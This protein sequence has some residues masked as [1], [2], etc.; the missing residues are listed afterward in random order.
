MT[1]LWGWL[2]GLFSASVRRQLIWGVALV[3]AAMMTLFVADLTVKQHE[4]LVDS[5]VDQAQSLAETLSVTAITPMLSSD[6]SGLQELMVAVAKYPGV[7]HVMAVHRSGKILAHSDPARRGQY[8]GDLPKFSATAQGKGQI[9]SQTDG[10]VDVVTPVMA[11]QQRLGWVRVG[12]GPSSAAARLESISRSGLLYTLLAIG[13][14]VLLAW[15]LGWRLTRRLSELAKVA[16]S[17]RAGSL[18]HRANALGADELSHLANAFNF[19]L[20]TLET[21]VHNERQLQVELSA[22]KELAQVTLASIGDAVITT[23]QTAHI[24]FMNAV[25]ERLTGWNGEDAVGH[26]VGE[27]FCLID[28]ATHEPL[29]NPVDRVQSHAATRLEHGQPPE[30][31]AWPGAVAPTEGLMLARSGQELAVESSAAPIFA[32]DG[33]VLGGVLV[34]RDVSEKHKIQ[35]RLQWQAGHDPLTGLPNRVLLADRFARALDR[36][37]RQSTR[38]AVCMLDLDQFKPVND[39]YGH[40][41]GDEL[42]VQTAQ[43]LTQ[44]LRGIDTLCRLGGDEFVILF[45]DVEDSSTLYRALERILLL[46]AE[47]FDVDGHRISVSASVGMTVFPLDDSDS[48]TLM[49][50]ADQA[51]YV[52]K[53]SGRNRYHLFDVSQDLQM[54]STRQTL[55][56]VRQA[57]HQGELRLHYQPKVNLRTHK[58]VG[59]EA[60]LRWQHPQEGLVPP[61]QFLPLVEQ[62]DVIV[63]IGEWVTEQALIQMACWRELGDAWPVS[64]NIAARH[65]QRHDFLERLKHILARHPSV[66]PSMLEFEILESVALGD[67]HAMNALMTNCQQLGISFSLDDFG[68]GY[69]SLSYLKHLP[70]QTL[71]IDQSFVR[72]MREDKDDLALVGAVV[73]IAHQFGRQVVAEGVETVEQGQQLLSLGCEIVQGYGIAR[74]M[75]PEAVLGWVQHYEMTKQPEGV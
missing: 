72:N 40:E 24:T 68:T 66:A 38:L 34:F 8:V 18:T 42:L 5:Q 35:Q 49:R 22:E 45:E 13:V 44:E 71:K 62:S 7:V 15:I 31:G 50:H 12:V 16:D 33:E 48:D 23:N 54:Q 25:A 30:D 19:M 11:N 73:N 59:M 4:F 36:A 9:L 47:P 63:D 10:L 75:P 1:R 69:S 27:V 2:V 29:P 21:R 61:L 58:V 70:V 28:G 20:D 74:P 6:L 43:R 3:H 46:L 37:R 55:E 56:R 39:T 57:L 65:F 32:P 17:V 41:A 67:I 64:V 51:M 53:Q 60:L 52:A 26:A 14:G